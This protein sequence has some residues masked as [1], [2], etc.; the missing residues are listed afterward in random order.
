MENI[1]LSVR[2]LKKKYR[3]NFLALNDVNLDFKEG[4]FYALLGENG[5]GKSTLMRLITQNEHITS[6]EVLYKGVSLYS[7]TN[8]LGSDWV[9]VDERAPIS[10][11]KSL[12][13]WAAMTAASGVSYDHSIFNRLT[14][15]FNLDPDQS[16]FSLSRGQKA[17]ALFALGAPKKPKIYFLD[18]ITSVLDMGS[19]FALINFLENE[20]KER[21]CTVIMSTNIATELPSLNTHICFLKNGKVELDCHFN[22]LA[23]LFTKFITTNEEEERLALKAGGCFVSYNTDQS[24]TFVFKLSDTDVLLEALK[25]DNRKISISEIMTYYTSLAGI[26]L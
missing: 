14:K 10:L 13:A 1:V 23:H 7:L 12:K 21:K 4:Q 16:F 15:E 5:A 25:K 9:Y 17:K 2:S 3:N 8:S 19:R 22:E 26:K 11:N 6:G 20:V 18:E 24:K